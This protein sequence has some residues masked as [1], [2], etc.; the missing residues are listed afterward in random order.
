MMKDQTD[1]LVA[2]G[3]I[4]GMMATAAFAAEGFRVLCVDPAPP[5]T[6]EAD[7]GS[8]LR[9]TAFLMPSVELMEKAGFWARLAPHGAALKIMRLADAG[10]EDGQVRTTRDFI[11]SDIGQ[12]AFGYNFPNWLLR[13][14]LLEHLG[15]L[16]NVRFEAGVGVAS[17]LTRTKETLVSLTDG[18]QVRAHLVVAADGRTSRVR[19]AL[20]IPVRTTRYGQKAVVFAVTH[21]LPHDDVSTEVHRSG[22]PFTLVPLPDG[23]DGTY[24]SA[25]VWMETGQEVDRLFKLPDNAFSAAAS[26]RSGGVLGALTL[27]S[28]RRM[29]PIITQ[30]AA[31]LVG[32]RSALI[33]EAAHVMPPIGAQGLNMSLKDVATLRDEIVTARDKG[34]DWA[35]PAVLDRYARTRKAD[36][37]LRLTGVDLLNRA[38]MTDVQ[39]LMDLRRRGL[40]ALHGLTPVRYTAMKMGLGA[41]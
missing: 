4:A 30:S 37:E 7:D 28:A 5:V 11:A 14:E 8:D 35:S 6:D 32:Q 21:E 34:D 3:G 39:P 26:E 9:S 33:A 31:Q 24:R 18:R 29:W 27:A 22:G 13:R 20:G 41:R 38:A 12:E 17:M 10:G 40:E 15:T 25:V 23:P 16:K 36:I 2:G 1:I 19:D